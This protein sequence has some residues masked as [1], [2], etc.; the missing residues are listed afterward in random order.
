MES[1]EHRVAA[2]DHY[3]DALAAELEQAAQAAHAAGDFRQAGQM[4]RW[5]SE[6]SSD[7]AIRNRR[8]LDAVIDMILARDIAWVRQ[9]LPAVRSAPDLA[10]R[11]VVQ[12]LMFG[13]EKR[14]LDAWATYTSVSEAVLDQ[15]DSVA[16]YRLLVLTAWSMICAGRDLEELAPL[17]AR[18]ATSRPADRAL[19]G[20]EIFARGMLGLRRSDAAALDETVN[21]IPARSSDTPLQ[22]TYKLAWRGSVHAFWGNAAARKPIWPR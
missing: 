11:A 5:A 1:L 9:Q 10:R 8:W 18:A 6:L 7:A 17:L 13:V 20:N 14:W 2:A 4:F 19:I 12:G 21:S 15:A 16:R 22:L 3:D